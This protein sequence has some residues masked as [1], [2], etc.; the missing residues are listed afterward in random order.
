MVE[1]LFLA[2]RG[3]DVEVNVY[4]YNAAISACEKG[5]HWQLAF[6]LFAEMALSKVDRDVI[7]FNAAFSACEKGRKWQLALV[8][9]A[10]MISD[11]AVC[12]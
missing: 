1:G 11:P 9:L 3:L 12:A 2:L 6:G 10:A 8:L 5:R 7:T 4:H